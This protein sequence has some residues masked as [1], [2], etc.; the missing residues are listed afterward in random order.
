MALM[1]RFAA[2]AQGVV[3]HLAFDAARMGSPSTAH[4]AAAGDFLQQRIAPLG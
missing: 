4:A 1:E 3:A 2:M